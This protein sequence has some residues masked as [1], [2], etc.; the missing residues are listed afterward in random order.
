MFISLGLPLLYSRHVLS[1]KLGPCVALID[2]LTHP[3]NNLSDSRMHVAS[4]QPTLY[5]S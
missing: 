4:D 1:C 2:S 3:L 5:V